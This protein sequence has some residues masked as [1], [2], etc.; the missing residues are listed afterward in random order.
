M[1]MKCQVLIARGQPT[2]YL[3]EEQPEIGEKE[4]FKKPE[5]TSYTTFFI[6]GEGIL[7]IQWLLRLGCGQKRQL[8]PNLAQKGWTNLINTWKRWKRVKKGG[9]K[10][11]NW[12]MDSVWLPQTPFTRG[13]RSRAIVTENIIYGGILSFSVFARHL[14]LSR[15]A[16]K[17]Q[18]GLRIAW[19]KQ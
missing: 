4:T 8:G 17:S 6:P 14:L 1:N 13:A 7:K 5:P 15:M 18:A 11:R 10:G 3:E 9:P 12:Q 16:S 19:G 2:Q